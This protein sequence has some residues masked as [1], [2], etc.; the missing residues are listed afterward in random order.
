MTACESHLG[1]HGYHC[2]AFCGTVRGRRNSRSVSMVAVVIE[3]AVFEVHVEA[4][5]TVDH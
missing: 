2:C 1:Y 3:C 5:E 4:E